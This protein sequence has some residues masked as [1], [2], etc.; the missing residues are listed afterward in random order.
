M[1]AKGEGMYKMQH[2]F[3]EQMAMYTAYHRDVRNCATHFIGVPMIVFA[4]LIAMSHLPIASA[5]DFPVTLATL[6]LAALLLLYLA[7][8]PLMGIVATVVHI[9]LLWFAHTIAAGEA[10]QSWLVAGACFVAGWIIQFVGHV[11]EGRRP[12]LFDN[13]IQ[14]FM[15]PGFLVTE[16]LFACGLLHDLNEDLEVRAAKYA[17]GASS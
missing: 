14:V 4:L 2:W 12:A 11:F 1:S 17:K 7:T 10:G 16:A 8:V 9:P 15:A 5:G 3:R 6:F 13:L